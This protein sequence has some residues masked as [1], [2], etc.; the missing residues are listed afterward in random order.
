MPEHAAPA[1]RRG[2]P[3]GGS[4]ARQRIVAAATAEFSDLGYDGATMR[5]IA[6]RAG[7]DAALLHHYFGTK[8]D[9]FGEIVGAPMRPDLKIPE[10]LAGP[11]DRIGE[12]I[13]RYVLDVWEQPEAR[14][15]GILVLRSAIGN[16]VATPLF[17]GFLSRELL[18]R[19]AAGIGLPDA[20]LRA[21]LVAT[22][23]AGLLLARYVLRL[24]PLADASVDELVAWVAPTIQRYLDAPSP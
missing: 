18:V 1:K 6:G 2:R 13:L 16:K 3:R 8:A 22:Q 20:E 17:A 14:R 9:L 12:A 19:I 15:R 11:R 5:G 24:A 10:I 4:D 23:V 21:S 7:V